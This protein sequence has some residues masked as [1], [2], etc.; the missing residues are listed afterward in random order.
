MWPLPWAM[1][2][3][4]PPNDMDG[5]SLWRQILN[6]LPSPRQVTNPRAGWIVCFSFGILGFFDVSCVVVDVF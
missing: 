6:D 1:S 3:R 5:V 2:G 4:A